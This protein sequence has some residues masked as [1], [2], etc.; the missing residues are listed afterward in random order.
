MKFEG[1]IP[2]KDK[3]GQSYGTFVLCK[4]V[5]NARK[6]I[7]TAW[8]KETDTLTIIID[9]RPYHVRPKR[10]AQF[11]FSIQINDDGS[12]Y[13]NCKSVYDIKKLYGYFKTRDFKAGNVNNACPYGSQ[14]NKYC[15]GFCTTCAKP[16]KKCSA[17]AGTC[18]Y[19]NICDN[20]VAGEGIC[21][22][23]WIEKW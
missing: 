22:G 18:C 10:P 5:Y 23:R 3:L 11:S 14:R 7:K 19:G 4:D 2:Q 17:N 21:Q 6:V 8:E 20:V 15:Y 9:L 1:E 13:P 12:S 16:G